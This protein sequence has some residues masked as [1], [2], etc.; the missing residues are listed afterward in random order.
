MKLRSYRSALL[1]AISLLRVLL[2]A[3]FDVHEL[4]TAQP[5]LVFI[6]PLCAPRLWRCLCVAATLCAGSFV[7]VHSFIA[8]NIV[9]ALI[10]DTY[11]TVQAVPYHLR[12]T[13]SDKPPRLSIACSCPCCER[14]A[15]AALTT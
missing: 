15:P 8:L 10:I 7:I 4:Y 14:D 12:E 13:T 5:D 11:C 6:L 3:D 1:A 9:R 2:R